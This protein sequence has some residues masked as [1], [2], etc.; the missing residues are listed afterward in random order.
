MIGLGFRIMVNNP[1]KMNLHEFNT[2]PTRV[3]G[4]TSHD[5]KDKISSKKRAKAVRSATSHAFHRRAPPPDAFAVVLQL[6]AFTMS[7]EGSTMNFDSLSIKVPETRPKP[8]WSAKD[9]SK[10]RRVFDQ[11]D[12]DKSGTVSLAELFSGLAKDKALSRT[13]G[14]PADD[15]SDEKRA[16]IEAI[17][18]G[19]DTDGNAE[20]DFEEFGYF[21]AERVEVLRYLPAEGADETQ[22]ILEN[23]F[24][25]LVRGKAIELKEAF[26][27]AI[28]AQ[29]ETA[30][31]EVSQDARENLYE[32]L[33]D[34][35]RDSVVKLVDAYANPKDIIPEMKKFGAFLA[36]AGC[37][38]NVVKAHYDA[39][40]K[41]LA[42][43]AGE[44]T[45]ASDT[46][47]TTLMSRAFDMVKSGFEEFAKAEREA[48]EAKAA[49]EA[50]NAAKAAEE[51]KAAESEKKKAEEE[52]KAAEKAAK[53]AKDE[54]EKAAAE[55]SAKAAEEAKAAAEAA[56]AKADAEKAEA[57]AAKKA[58][59][60]AKKAAEE[61][62]KKKAAEIEA[63]NAARAKEDEERNIAREKAAKAK[64]EEDA[65][66][67]EEEKEAEKARAA[68]AKAAAEAAKAARQKREAE[69]A[70]KAEGGPMCGCLGLPF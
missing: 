57:E 60:E 35:I 38:V 42:S 50:A 13:L 53:Q 27:T 15:G 9:E 3:F 67:S 25:D 18:K 24:E 21:F 47:W 26:L 1:K 20:L 11:C 51:A 14:I 16:E 4:V 49:E 2:E 28:D 41:A 44:W 19:L 70:K 59:E 68:E 8:N 52:A 7:E 23:E 6:H 30:K 61:A 64:A 39:Y 58:A 55:A 65:K 43:V 29:Y 63:A 54:E 37:D 12:E 22:L 66:K 45:V 40:P 36:R 31:L 5:G 46:A 34:D 48:Q 33:P 56:K 17:F 69:E 62:A 10:I 32:P